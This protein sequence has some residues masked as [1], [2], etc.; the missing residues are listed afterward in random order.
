MRSLRFRKL[1]WN[2]DINFHSANPVSLIRGII[3]T[4]CPTTLDANS[5]ESRF[6]GLARTGCFAR[7]YVG[8]CTGTK[9]IRSDMR[10]VNVFV[11]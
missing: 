6:L 11:V 4:Q 2:K 5:V 1:L 9:P 3:L 10:R 8:Q 7:K